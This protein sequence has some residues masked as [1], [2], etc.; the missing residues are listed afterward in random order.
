MARRT[1]RE[2]FLAKIDASGPTGCWLWTGSRVINYKGS[3]TSGRFW[4]DKSQRKVYAHRFAWEEYRGPIP[5]GMQVVHTCSNMGCANPDHLELRP[6]LNENLVEV[7]ELA[8]T[9]GKTSTEALDHHAR[10]H[11]AVMLRDDAIAKV[12]MGLTTLEEAVRVTVTDSRR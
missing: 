12:R 2:R 7:V 4:D 8:Q 6:H 5:P 3:P 9:L 10:E 11:G 1:R